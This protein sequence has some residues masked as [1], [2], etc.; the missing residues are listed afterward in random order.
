M[1]FDNVGNLDWF[2]NIS[3]IFI[4]RNLFFHKYSLYCTKISRSQFCISLAFFV[5]FTVKNNSNFYKQQQ[6]YKTK[7]T[8]GK[9]IGQRYIVGRRIQS[10]NNA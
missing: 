1:T 3:N 7:K 9:A 6:K 10:E 8:I 4:I 2:W 5:I